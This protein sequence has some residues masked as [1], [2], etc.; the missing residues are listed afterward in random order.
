[1]V[2]VAILPLA[3]KDKFCEVTNSQSGII[4]RPMAMQ[5]NCMALD[6]LTQFVINSEAEWKHL[7][8]SSCVL[9]R[10]DFTTETLIGMR[11]T[12][13][14]DMGYAREVTRFDSKKQ[15]HYRVIT[16]TCGHCER[17]E[18][19]FNL[20]VVPKLPADYTV[21]FELINNP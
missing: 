12:G 3:C 1:M 21:T 6:T 18:I 13:Q 2:L 15:Y 8:D 4:L 17:M 11:T 5:G 16:S 20:V 19:N 7:V 10:I 14:C 9:S